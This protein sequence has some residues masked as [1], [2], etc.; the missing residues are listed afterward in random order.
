MYEK[1]PHAAL[2]VARHR[3]RKGRAC[4]RS[5]RRSIKRW[6][7]LFPL[8]AISGLVIEGVNPTSFSSGIYALPVAL[9]AL[10]R[11]NG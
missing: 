1:A 8:Y 2:R 3:T 9:A 10:D 5:A 7:S 4:V 6:V 11:A